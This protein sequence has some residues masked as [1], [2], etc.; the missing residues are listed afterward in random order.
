[1]LHTGRGFIDPFCR[2]RFSRTVR[3]S[4]TVHEQ[5]GVYEDRRIRVRRFCDIGRRLSQARLHDRLCRGTRIL[6]L[7][8]RSLVG[9]RQT[10]ASMYERVVRWYHRTMV[11][12]PIEKGTRIVVGGNLQ[13]YALA[14]VSYCTFNVHESRWGIIVEWPNAPGGPSYS[15]VWDTDE[16]KTWYRYGRSN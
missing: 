5:L 16:G 7:D 9:E 1:M 3:H 12:S 10:L 11:Q 2:R 14:I 8:V 13:P 6:R 4:G 15:R